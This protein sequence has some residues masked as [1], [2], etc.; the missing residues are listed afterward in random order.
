MSIFLFSRSVTG[1]RWGQTKDVRDALRRELAAERG[2]SEDALEG[3]SFPDHRRVGRTLVRSELLD[4]LAAALEPG[5]S[6]ED[7][8]DVLSRENVTDSSSILSELG[9][10]VVWEG[11]SGGTLR[12][13]E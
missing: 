5:M 9:Y 2:V 10:E 8:E 1:F 3:V 12:R 6:L 7:A 4:E 13:T 11:L